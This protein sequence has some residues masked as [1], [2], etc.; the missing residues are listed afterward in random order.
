[1]LNFCF[2]SGFRIDPW[3]ARQHKENEPTHRHDELAH[4]L[5]GGT[6]K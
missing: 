4:F 1:M 2:P 6:P 5:Y 3:I